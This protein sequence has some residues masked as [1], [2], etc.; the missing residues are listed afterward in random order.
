MEDRQV[1]KVADVKEFKMTELDQ[2]LSGQGRHY[3]IYKKLHYV[4]KV[5]NLYLIYKIF[6]KRKN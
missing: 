3:N 2:Y 4:K 6:L 1:R 5:K